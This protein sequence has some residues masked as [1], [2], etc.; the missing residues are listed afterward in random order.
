MWQPSC[1]L[2]L[3]ADPE[4]SLVTPKRSTVIGPILV[5]PLK[6]Q[7]T[8]GPSP[9]LYHVWVFST[10]AWG[11]PRA[12]SEAEEP[13]RGGCTAYHSYIPC[14]G[15]GLHRK[16]APNPCNEW[17]AERDLDKQSW[18]T[19][20]TA[21]KSH[22]LGWLPEFPSLHENWS[23]GGDLG[24][25]LEEAEGHQSSSKSQG[26]QAPMESWDTHHCLSLKQVRPSS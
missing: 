14:P 24:K 13:P 16:I 18:L 5:L 26:S 3:R 9:H 15:W 6:S 17:V 8:S 23:L 12:A 22:Q 7:E 10:A 25:K 21:V 20:G 1:L 11:L 2:V 19:S 4:G